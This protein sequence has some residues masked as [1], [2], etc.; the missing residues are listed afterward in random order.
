MSEIYVARLLALAGTLDFFWSGTSPN[1]DNTGFSRVIV[2][3]LANL[4]A[5]LAFTSI[6][7]ALRERAR[8]GQQP[9]S[10]SSW[11]TSTFPQLTDFANESAEADNTPLNAEERVQIKRVIEEIR[12]YITTTSTLGAEPLAK[13]NR[14]L[15]YLI[16]ASERVGRKDLKV[17]FLGIL[18]TFVYEGLIPS[19]PDLRELFGIAGHLLRQVLGGGMSPPLLH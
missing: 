1:S 19:G 4:A 3:S 6:E 8:K 13:I 5:F 2:S 12:I 7:N 18:C 11:G 14:K 10:P 16:D 15:D 9:A 17:L